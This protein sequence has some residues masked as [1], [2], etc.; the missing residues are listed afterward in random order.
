MLDK[1]NLVA[2][3]VALVTGVVYSTILTAAHEAETYHS[4][5]TEPERELVCDRPPPLHP[6]PP[7]HPSPMKLRIF[8]QTGNHGLTIG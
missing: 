7:H 6:L 1:R 4:L 8:R 3:A 2:A 5:L